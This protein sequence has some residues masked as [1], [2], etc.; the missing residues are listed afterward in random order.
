MLFEKEEIPKYREK[1]SM[2]NLFFS[3]FVIRNLFYEFFV[4]WDKNL[5]FSNEIYM[6]V[7]L[8]IG[9]FARESF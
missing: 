1:H 3:N 6:Y 2:Y 4:Y 8:A 5:E 9:P 7:L